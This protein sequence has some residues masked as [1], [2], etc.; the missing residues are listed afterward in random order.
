MMSRAYAVPETV[1]SR[2]SL[3]LVAILLFSVFAGIS[4]TPTVSASVNGDLEITTSISPM[5]NDYMTSWDAILI[6][7]QVTNTGFFY[8]TD[9]REIEFFV[10]E[11]VQEV[12]ACFLDREERGTG[13]IEP[14]GIG[15]TST[16]T[17]NTG[18]SP[19][20]KEG[21]FTLVYRFV[22]S[23]DNTSNDVK[24]FTVYFTQRLVD[25]SFEAQDPTSQLTDVAIYNDEV[26]LN[27]NK[28][29]SMNINGM[30]TSCGQ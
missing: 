4:F 1:S 21:A 16:Y 20:G 19:N 10:C 27:T 29:Y 2:K 6:T 15:Q 24:A 5:P 9:S 3:G 14:I 22:E 18:F 26:I 25:I 13:L 7:V 17:F 23:D 11:G 8:N 30:V 12:N 28:D